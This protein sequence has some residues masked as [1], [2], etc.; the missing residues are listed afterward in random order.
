MLI[1]KLIARGMIGCTDSVNYAEIEKCATVDA[2]VAGFT[3]AFAS[4]ESGLDTICTRP[5][6]IQ[7]PP[8][9][10]GKTGM[11]F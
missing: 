7:Q 5:S 3:P 10:V 11:R 4:W 9:L 6:C 1:R 8:R 2:S